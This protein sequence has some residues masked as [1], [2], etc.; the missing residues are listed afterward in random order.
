MSTFEI[1]QIV[2]HN[3]NII[4]LSLI[5]IKIHDIGIIRELTN[6]NALVFFPHENGFIKVAL[7][8]LIIAPSNIELPKAT[9][10]EKMA[11]IEYNMFNVNNLKI[12]KV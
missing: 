7:K 10:S 5:D 4:N 11:K 1:N 12:F 2:I 3:H 6:N 8:N 9:K